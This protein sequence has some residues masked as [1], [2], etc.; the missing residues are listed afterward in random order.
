MN[1]AVGSLLSLLNKF[2]SRQD[3]LQY[4]KHIT[5]YKSLSVTKY[6]AIEIT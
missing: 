1:A 5:N 6:G 2:L 3:S 4:F